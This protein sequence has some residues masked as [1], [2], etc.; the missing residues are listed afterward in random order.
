MINYLFS[1]VKKDIGFSE[2]QKDYLLKS[3]KNGMN[4]SFVASIPDNYER[5]DEQVDKYNACFSKIGISFDNIYFVDGRKTK[6]E[7]RDNI[8]NSD[9][10]FLL[11][12]SPDLQMKFINEYELNDSILS[13]KIVIGVSAGS[14]NQ[15]DRVIYKDDFKDY[16]L[17]DYKGLNLTDVNIYP[18]YDT[19]DQECLSEVEEVSGIH[20]IVCLPDESFIYIVNGNKEIVGE[21]YEFVSNQKKTK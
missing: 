13:A 15:G 5:T 3:I 19:S 2:I 12:G 11:G 17:E 21:Y 7:A 1:Q 6:E 4:I 9:I 14:M 18:H 8:T 20:P 16:I 10:V